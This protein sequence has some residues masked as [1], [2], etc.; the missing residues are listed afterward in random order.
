MITV[1]KPYLPNRERL[2]KYIDEI[3]A[4][5]QLTNHGRLLS[6]LE[7]RLE[8]LFGVDNVICV[9]NGT[10][11]LQVA[12]KSLGLKGEVITTPFSYAATTTSLKWEGLTPRFSD[13]DSKTLN[14]DPC[15]IERKI[16]S[17]TSAIVGVHVYGNPCDH[18]QIQS[19]ARGNG[20]KLI[21]DAAHCFGVHETAG[22]GKESKSVFMLGDIST[23]SFHATKLFHTVEGGALI[24]ND[25]ALARKIRRMINFGLPL[26]E[27]ENQIQG[28]NAKLSEFHAAM[29]L[30]V[31]DDLELINE[32]RRSIWDI[33]FTQLRDSVEFQLWNPRYANNFAYAPII[34]RCEDSLLRVKAKLEN[35]NIMSRRYFFPSLPKIF[36][37]DRDACPISEDIS[38]R[39]LCLPIY[40]DLSENDATRIAE[41]VKSEVK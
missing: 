11:A 38:H 9:A 41:Y 37:Q 3:Y 1:T 10:L 29:G 27:D 28:T 22:Y 16:N 17:R 12:Y 21:Y 20:L 40:P 15:Q 26:G 5:S 39:I 13:I 36:C 24:V 31:L 19:L 7:R 18:P 25:A 4:S 23:V 34:F 30:A 6:E 35:V 33:Y 14:V 2:N 8:E 32:C